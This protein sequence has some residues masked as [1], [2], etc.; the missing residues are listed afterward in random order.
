[1][2]DA[3]DCLTIVIDNTLPVGCQ[4]HRHDLTLE[5]P[6]D[7]A[8]FGLNGH[9]L[10]DRFV[11]APSLTGAVAFRPAVRVL[12]LIADRLAVGIDY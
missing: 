7:L 1:M 12:L 5:L 4:R 8:C 6:E 11:P 2:F 10:I 3:H 9:K